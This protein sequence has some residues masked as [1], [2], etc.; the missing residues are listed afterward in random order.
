MILVGVTLIMFDHRHPQESS[1]DNKHSL[2]AI[3]E[4]TTLI[5]DRRLLS[6]AP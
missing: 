2:Q 1:I 5:N 4:E 6:E 3:P